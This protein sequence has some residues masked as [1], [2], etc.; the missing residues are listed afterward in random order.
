M[1]TIGQR[2]HREIHKIEEFESNVSPLHYEI[3][4][5]K[6]FHQLKQISPVHFNMMHVKF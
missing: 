3:Y 4:V 1:H 6:R 5:T 2:L